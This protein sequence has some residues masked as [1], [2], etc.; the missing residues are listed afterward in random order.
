MENNSN[1]LNDSTKVLG[2]DFW[3]NQYIA[4]STGWDLGQVSPPLKEY[5]DQISDKNL[6]ILIPGCG[7]SYEAEYL[8][9]QGF[10]NVNL[11]DIAPELVDRLKTKFKSKPQINII[12]GDFFEHEGEYD[13]ILEQT[14]FCALD[15][16]L[17]KNYVQ[18]MADL[19]KNGGK[20]AGLLFSRIFEIAGPPFGGTIEEY[21]ELFKE[22][23]DFK[24]FD[25]CYNSFEKRSGN[26]LFVVLVKSNLTV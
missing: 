7:N 8:L 25:S 26:E 10:N 14:F 22:K 17:R 12:L 16:I 23:F 6:K 3:N 24:V 11:I 21:Q 15:P 4:Q 19:L 1:L 18:K 20:I 5:I 13:L 2:Q 9:E